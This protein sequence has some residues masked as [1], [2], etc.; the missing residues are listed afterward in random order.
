M[1]KRSIQETGIRLSLAAV[2]L[3]LLQLANALALLT[4]L[5]ADPFHVFLQGLMRRT[6]S[7]YGILY[8]IASLI[9]LAVLLFFRS[10]P[11][12]G[13]LL[14][15][16]LGGWILEG[17]LRLFAGWIGEELI[18]PVR[19][20]VLFAC[21]LLQA[22][23][24]ALLTQSDSGTLPMEL[25][26]R[27]LSVRLQKKTDLVILCCDAVLI[28]AGMLLG[29]RF[30]IGT[31]LLVFLSGILTGHFMGAAAQVVKRATGNVSA[32]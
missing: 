15:A 21:C 22:F 12:S 24:I 3:V 13:S 27:H 14:C 18:F 19:L 5:G 6:G 9:L 28:L 29:G 2:G 1:R 32:V 30:G 20:L 25:F 26:L 7:S 10:R 16:F 17:F 31:V 11:Q 4:A 8:M 23:G